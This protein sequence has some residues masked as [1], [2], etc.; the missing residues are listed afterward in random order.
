[1]RRDNAGFGP[2]Q[3]RLVK[4]KAMLQNTDRYLGG[5]NS[6]V[7][8]LGSTASKF[9]TYSAAQL[10]HYNSDP[11]IATMDS[12]F[13]PSKSSPMEKMTDEGLIQTYI[14]MKNR[15][16]GEKNFNLFYRLIFWLLFSAAVNDEIYN[17]ELSSI[18]DLAYCLDFNEALM[19]DW[20]KVV[21]FVIGGGKLSETSPLTL[22]TAEANEFFLHVNANTYAEEA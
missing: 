20:C 18:V 16:T 8:M 17:N 5:R 9:K 1:M 19:R 4:F 11:L 15:T 21:V 7:F 13:N 14:E 12:M 22:E 2:E 6:G 3:M 10:K